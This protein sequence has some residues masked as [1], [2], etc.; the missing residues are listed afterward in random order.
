MPHIRIIPQVIFIAAGLFP[1]IADANGSRVFQLVRPS[2]VSISA[3]LPGDQAR[4]GSGV[5]VAVDEILTNCHVVGNANR[6]SVRFSDGEQSIATIKGRVGKL[7]LC[8]L[9]TTTKKRRAV[10]VAPLAEVQIGQAI[11]AVGDPLSLRATMSDGIVSALREADAGWVIQVTSPISPGS[12]GGGLF[13]T[14]GRLIGITTFTLTE[15]QNINFAIPAEY[16]STVVFERAEPNKPSQD[17]VTFKG[18]PFGSSVNQFL[19]AFPGTKCEPGFRTN[20]TIC[21]GG[22][23]SYLSRSGNY[24]AWFTKNRLVTVYVEMA[25]KDPAGLAKQLQETL[26]IRF[27]PPTRE[28]WKKYT[29]DGVEGLMAQW[30]LGDQEISISFCTGGFFCL[31]VGTQIILSDRTLQWDSSPSKDF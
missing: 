30:L 20:L 9:S 16:R 4:H 14:K 10:D 15:G 8:A 25:D 24:S 2:V 1:V 12:S 7:D 18:V 26:E 21:E 22:A 27:G 17:R 23:I 6:I 3:D 28:N 31:I 19:E 5:I 29:E 11:Y 13:D